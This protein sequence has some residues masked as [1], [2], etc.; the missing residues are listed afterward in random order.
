VGPA[1]WH[2]LASSRGGFLGC[3][4]EPSPRVAG[5]EGDADCPPCREAGIKRWGRSRRAC[6]Y[7]EVRC[8]GFAARPGQCL[9]LPGWLCFWP[10]AKAQEITLEQVVVLLL[11]G[12]LTGHQLMPAKESWAVSGLIWLVAGTWACGEL[13]ASP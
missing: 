7:T 5:S 13:P 9:K 3:A 8:R 6:P 1:L 4:A 2:S 10:D 11:S 12:I